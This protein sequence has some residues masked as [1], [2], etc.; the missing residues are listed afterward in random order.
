MPFYLILFH[1][2]WFHFTLFYS[3]SFHFICILFFIIFYFILCARRR[4]APEGPGVVW[5]DLEGARP[6]ESAGRT[7]AACRAAA[8][9]GGAPAGT[10]AVLEVGCIADL[11]KQRSA[12][13]RG[14]SSST[15]RQVLRPPLPPGRPGFSEPRAH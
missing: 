11:S 10:I 6:S 13:G 5:E 15:D 3:T 2:I 4:A 14:A 12:S 9:A 1:S 8:G 7:A